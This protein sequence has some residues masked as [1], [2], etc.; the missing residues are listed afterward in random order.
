VASGLAS[1]GDPRLVQLGDGSLLLFSADQ[2][3]VVTFSSPGGGTSWSGP[4]KTASSDTGDVQEAAVR[5]DGT[6]LF[7]Q[8]GTGF[9]DVYQGALVHNVFPHCCGYAESLVV[10][11]HGL[12]QIAFWSNATGRS[13]YLYAGSTGPAGSPAACRRSRRARPQSGPTACRSPPTRPGTRSSPSRT[14]IRRPRSSS[15]RAGA[16]RSSTGSRSLTARSPG[17]SP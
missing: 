14:A 8:D 11:S 16:A 10:D 1:V 15:R 6:T 12:A 3:G 9:V 5:K 4:G 2:D 13:G 17:T 7:A